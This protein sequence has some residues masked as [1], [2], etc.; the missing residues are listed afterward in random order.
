MLTEICNGIDI[1]W[2][3]QSIGSALTGSMLHEHVQM[4]RPLRCRERRPRMA[5]TAS[6][7]LPNP[8][9]HLEEHC[10][11]QVCHECPG[12]RSKW[13][14]TELAPSGGS[15][16]TEFYCSRHGQAANARFQQF[17][18]SMAQRRSAR[19]TVL[20]VGRISLTG[21]RSRRNNLATAQLTV[22]P[23]G[24]RGWSFRET[25]PCLRMPRRYQHCF[26]SLRGAPPIAGCAL[27]DSEFRVSVFLPATLLAPALA[28]GGSSL[29][30][31]SLS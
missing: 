6:Q 3:V 21:R 19:G 13:R 25:G 12:T 22:R 4:G 31:A 24:G 26:K 18:K 15:Y 16:L 14:L 9:L 28:H 30:N 8:L 23:G 10:G 7:L 29:W 20:W 27:N 1:P 5:P 2:D 17:S 11:D